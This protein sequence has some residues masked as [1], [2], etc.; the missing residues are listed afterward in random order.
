MPVGKSLG[1]SVVHYRV[2]VNGEGI[3]DTESIVVLVGLD[4][5]QFFSCHLSS[6]RTDPILYMGVLD[7][8]YPDTRC[9]FFACRL[10]QAQVFIHSRLSPHFILFWA[11]NCW[12]VFIMVG[13][14]VV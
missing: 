3:A 13:H 2:D 9:G 8:R 14:L 1:Q 6:N 4:C 12:F 5:I 10:S 11:F 7:L